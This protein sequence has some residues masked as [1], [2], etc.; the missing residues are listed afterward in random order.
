[1]RL[2]DEKIHERII[3]K[4][5]RL[6]KHRPLDPIFLQRLRRELMIEYTFD[7]NAIEGSTLTLRETRLVIEEGITVGGKSIQEYLGARNHPDAIE[8]IEKVVYEKKPL[9]EA[10]ILE[11]HRLILRNIEEHA[12]KYRTTGVRIGGALFMPPKSSEVPKLMLNLLMWLDKNIEEYTP[13]EQ[14]AL[15]H[16]KFIQIHPFSDGNGR[17]AR[18]LMNVILMKSGY[19]FIV[20]VTKKDRVKYLDSLREADMGNKSHF[21][22]FIARSSERALDLYLNALEEPDFL[23]L[24]EASKITPYSADYLGLL[25]RKGRIG[26]FKEGN[27]WYIT[28]DEL[29]KYVNDMNKRK[30]KK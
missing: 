19:P 12:G 28:K 1:M 14:A 24:V 7:S 17:I 30:S 13:I 26:A 8:Y 4:K 3:E 9:Y 20:N 15:F 22:N 29:L 11:L 16:H 18:L 27:K 23:T 2:I 10:D 21:V 5:K 25:V 6:D